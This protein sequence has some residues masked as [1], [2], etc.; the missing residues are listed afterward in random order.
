MKVKRGVRENVINGKQIGGKPPFGYDYD[1]EGHYVVNPIE[2]PI[3]QDVFRM[4]GI[5]KTSM[6]EIVRI[7]DSEAKRQ[8][9]GN[10]I[11]HGM[12]ER[13]LGNEKYVGVLQCDGARNR[14]G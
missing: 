10:P 13:S 6:F 5:E 2:G 14:V 12:L 9:N 1:K 7:L 3:L 11:T 4:Y 8:K